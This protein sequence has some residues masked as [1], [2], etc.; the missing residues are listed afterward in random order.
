MPIFNGQGRR[1]KSV[2]DIRQRFADQ[3]AE[4]S[5][6][7]KQSDRPDPCGGR[8]P[9]DSPPRMSTGPSE[10]RNI[11]CDRRRSATSPCKCSGAAT[12]P[13]VWGRPRSKGDSLVLT[14]SG[15]ALGSSTPSRR[16]RILDGRRE[17]TGSKPCARRNDAVLVDIGCCEIECAGLPVGVGGADARGV[18]RSMG[19]VCER[20]SQMDPVGGYQA[21]VLV[22][23]LSGNLDAPWARDCNQA[24]MTPRH[25]T[26]PHPA[27]AG[28]RWEMHTHR[29][30][31]LI[32]P[33]VAVDNQ[34]VARTHEAAPI[35][36]CSLKNRC[37][38]RSYIGNC[39][40]Y[41]C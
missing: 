3:I 16:G 22:H 10:F 37:H 36:P 1:S 9:A 32:L 25:A 20:G 7:R 31:Q 17:S 27:A 12:T 19:G 18:L 8:G 30:R 4:R 33:G 15:V 13:T 5:D 14:L 26:R 41:C 34:A 40:R 2:R 24:C 23:Y 38:F 35:P 29:I 11:S 39:R 28:S 6:W 21:P